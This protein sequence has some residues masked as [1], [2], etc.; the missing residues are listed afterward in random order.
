MRLIFHP[1]FILMAI[2]PLQW[3]KL[4]TLGPFSVTPPY[5]AAVL[6]IVFALSSPARRLS[7]V[8][9][10]EAN[11]YWIIPFTL[12]LL[13]LWIVLIDSRAANMAPR[14]A[15]YMLAALAFGASLAAEQRLAPLLRWGCM[16]G[17]ALFIAVVEV[18]AQKVG[19]SWG[20]A[21]VQ[22]LASGDLDHMVYSFFR[23]A[24]NAGNAD[25]EI[26][27]VASAKNEPA[28]WLLIAAIMYRAAWDGKGPDRKGQAVFLLVIFLLIL[29][30]TRSVLLTAAGSL[31]LAHILTSGAPRR[32]GMRTW[33][34]AI[35]GLPMAALA[36][37]WFVSGGSAVVSTLQERLS[38]ADSSS[39]ARLVQFAYA[40]EKI[41]ADMLLGSGY[42]QVEGH[43]VHNLF[44]SAWMHA[45]TPAFLLVLMVIFGLVSGWFAMMLRVKR[46]PQR[47]VLPMRFEWVSALPLLAFF[48][49]WLSGDAGHLA[50]GEWL[51]LGAYLGLLLRN[52]VALKHLGPGP[53]AIR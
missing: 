39:G 17:I 9:F 47:W 53:V 4:A 35:I 44:L 41:E 51:A 30:N 32:I 52:N 37:A 23:A 22:F 46:E 19:M 29:L 24:F 14:Q 48:R 45:G 40:I 49:V 25:G 2:M 21:V 3:M 36:A 43:V 15:V 20:P 31:V 11:V 26:T 6:A 16:A 13:I 5:L 33:L 38:F 34:L 50:M 42:S 27:V 1:I 7:G 28:V 18:Q 8:R 10:L 12:Y